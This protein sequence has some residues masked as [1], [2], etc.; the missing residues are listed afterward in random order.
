M[1]IGAPQVDDP[2]VTPVEFGLV[3][4]NVVDKIS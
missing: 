2:V 3:V 4:R 1:M